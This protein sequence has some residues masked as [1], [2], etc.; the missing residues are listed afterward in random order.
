MESSVRNFLRLG[1]A[2]LKEKPSLSLSEFPRETRALLRRGS[3]ARL[4]VSINRASNGERDVTPRR[5]GL[6]A[7]AR[8]LRVEETAA[9]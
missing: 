3:S 1:E 5:R 8:S 4:I 9:G 6:R 2:K 7:C